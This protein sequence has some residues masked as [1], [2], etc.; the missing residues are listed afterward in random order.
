MER[1]CP[2][3]FDLL[4][5]EPFTEIERMVAHGPLARYERMLERLDRLDAELTQLLA[6]AVSGSPA[7]KG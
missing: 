6:G 4:L 1:T 5:D 3:E 2:A 7:E